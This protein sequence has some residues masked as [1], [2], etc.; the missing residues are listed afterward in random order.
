MYHSGLLLL[1]PGKNA[2][3]LV[4]C[5]SLEEEYSNKSTKYPEIGRGICVPQ[6]FIIS[7]P[8]SKAY[9]VSLYEGHPISNANSS[10]ISSLFEIS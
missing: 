7:S 10:T 8:E 4:R 2:V 1:L 5:R 3:C 9:K 6:W